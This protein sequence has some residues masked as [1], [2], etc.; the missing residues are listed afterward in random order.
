MNIETHLQTL[1]RAHHPPMT[2]FALAR[3]AKLPTPATALAW[4]PTMDVVVVAC[5]RGG[6]TLTAYRL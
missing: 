5:A 4:C 6:G 1:A 2:S 3:D